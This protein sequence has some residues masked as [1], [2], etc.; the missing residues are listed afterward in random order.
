MVH[1]SCFFPLSPAN[2][3]AME[4]NTDFHFIFSFFFILY[5]FFLREQQEDERERRKWQTTWIIYWMIIIIWTFHSSAWRQKQKVV[6]KNRRKISIG[7]M[8]MRC[9]WGFY[10]VK[11]SG[12]EHKSVLQNQLLLLN[13]E[14]FKSF[15]ASI[16][17]MLRVCRD[18]DRYSQKRGK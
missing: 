7:K 16:T 9:T 18:V 5:T 1:F 11:K 8:W 13:V 15:F 17:G 10:A 3:H 2:P 6:G 14:A 12:A 4:Y